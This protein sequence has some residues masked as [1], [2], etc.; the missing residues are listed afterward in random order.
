MKT[1]SK[2]I[3]TVGLA[4]AMLLSSVGGAAAAE[5]HY[6]DVKK[7][8]NF[9]NSVDFLIEQNAISK[10]LPKFRP[11]ENI[12]RGQ[13]ASIFAKILGL[14]VSNI[15]NPGFTDV[16]KTHQFY[17]YVAA[18]E[19]YGV[20][21]GYGNGK[22]GVNDQLTRGQMA[23]ILM[24]AYGIPVIHSE[25]YASLKSNFGES[26]LVKSNDIFDG[27]DFKNGQWN[28]ELETLEYF[29]VLGGYK[30]GNLYP[31]KPINR[32]QFANMIYKMEDYG[33]GYYHYQYV[34][35]IFD[36]FATIG[37]SE[38]EADE[39]FNEFI[40]S[41]ELVEFVT[42]YPIPSDISSDDYDLVMTVYPVKEGEMIFEDI[43][44]KIVVEYSEEDGWWIS[45]EKISEE[46]TTPTTEDPNIENTDSENTGIVTE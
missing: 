16:P 29:G 41:N 2:A 15:E 7:T 38:E 11:Y 9:Y 10:T 25:G 4:S 13:F 3:T 21:G 39:K 8:D 24:K 42:M 20:I 18:L 22:F 5:V 27:Y 28:D 34:D 35:S 45:V 43:N 33:F 36:D 46:S 31:N 17:K 32:S 40:N 37:V 23:G 44:A 14:D 30:D 1:I 6:K 26:N 12:T 19:N